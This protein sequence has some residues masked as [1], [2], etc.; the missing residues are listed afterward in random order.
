MLRGANTLAQ[1]DEAIAAAERGQESYAETI[2]FAERTLANDNAYLLHN[3]EGEM[4]TAA[5]G[6]IAN[7]GAEIAL[8]LTLD[9]SDQRLRTL[10][11]VA[12]RGSEVDLSLRA[13]IMETITALAQAEGRTP[14]PARLGNATRDSFFE[15][16]RGFDAQTSGG[17]LLSV[18]SD[19]A[20]EV[21]NAAREGGAQQSCIVGHVVQK[22]EVDLVIQ[23]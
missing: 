20:N 7:L 14:D 16:I 5:H 13:A 12:N 11:A 4:I 2:R 17:L 10:A 15:N 22:Q 6:E 19:K 1:F 21:V 9:P 3:A 8:E 23:S 18:P